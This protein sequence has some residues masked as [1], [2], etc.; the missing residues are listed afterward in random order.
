MTQRFV[1]A[2]A[3]MGRTLVLTASSNQSVFRRFAALRRRFGSQ[4]AI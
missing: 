3:M 2:P 1:H 4:K